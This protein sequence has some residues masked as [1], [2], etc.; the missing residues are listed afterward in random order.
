[1][2]GLFMGLGVVF[3]LDYLDNTIRTP[4]DVEKYLGLN[5]IGVVPKMQRAEADALAQRATKEA[6]QS[7]RTSIIFSSSNR[8]RKLALV[9]S[10]GPREGKSST[11][12]NLGRTLA[13]SGDRVVIIDCD[14]RKPKQHVHHGVE[15]EPGLTNYLAAPREESDWSVYLK[16]TE[17]ANLKLLTSG[18]LPPSPPDLLGNERFK[19]MLE[20]M[21]EVYDWVL[22]DSPPAASLADASL[23]ASLADMVVLVVQ[24]NSTDRDHIMKT[25]QQLGGVNPNFAGVVLNNVDM[26]RTYHKDYYYASY[27]YEDEEGRKEKRSRRK[28]VERKAQVG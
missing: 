8:Q 2:L 15:R 16:P 17:S 26:D 14:L 27:Y 9:T 28:S 24:H 19:Q 1:M 25:V 7:L 4:E 12:A 20:S 21:R 3:F 22:I 23:L 18:P 6:Y 11:V 13:T 5:V 10:T